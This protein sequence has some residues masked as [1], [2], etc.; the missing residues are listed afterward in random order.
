MG[1]TSFSEPQVFGEKHRVAEK[2]QWNDG[3]HKIENQ[4]QG[5]E[6]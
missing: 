3:P 2:R 4:D 6:C 5:K 1:D